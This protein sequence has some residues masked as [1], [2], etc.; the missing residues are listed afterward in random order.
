MAELEKRS[1]KDKIK[2]YLW[3]VVKIVAIAVGALATINFLAGV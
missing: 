1:P 2:E 3:Q